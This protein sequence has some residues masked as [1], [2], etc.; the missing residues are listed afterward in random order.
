MTSNDREPPEKRS[1][2]NGDPKIILPFSVSFS[3]AYLRHISDQTKHEER[4]KIEVSSG[5][6]VLNSLKL[7]SPK[8]F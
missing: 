2:G 4:I 7:P 6:D 5:Y 1:A 3:E 8:S